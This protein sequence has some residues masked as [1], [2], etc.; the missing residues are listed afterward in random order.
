MKAYK[1]GWVIVLI[2][3][4]ACA[5]QNEKVNDVGPDDPIA[6]YVVTAF[7]DSRGGLWFG[8]IGKGVAHPAGGQLTFLSPADGKGGDVV[9][10]IAEDTNGHCWFAGHEGTGL[11]R[12]D[13]SSF[14]QY[15]ADE[16]SVSTDRAG[17]VW[18]GTDRQV[19]R[20]DGPGFI[21]FPLP[22]DHDT[23]HTYA[24]KPG[25]ASLALQDSKGDLWFRTDG[26]GLIKYDGATFR[27]Y[28]KADGLCSNSVNDVVEDDD[29][30]I[31]VIGMQAYQPAMTHDGGLC[32][33]DGD[34]FITFP[35]IPGLHANDLYTIFKDRSGD[36]WI[37]ATG[38]GVYRF[39]DEHFT[40][41]DRTDR[42]D[43]NASFGLQGMTQ[44]DNGTLW[45][46]FSGGLFR[47]DGDGFVHVGRNGPWE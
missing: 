40:L 27:T 41:F 14:H 10:S 5:A 26:A 18:A 45:C 11:V 8:T 2:L 3:S 28:T 15:W 34:H 9:S 32:R 42:P 31:W 19:F 23:I 35:E 1:Q 36:L 30:R 6:Q 43:L 24:I 12:Y 29:G 20:S 16:T 44:A 37:G 17:T 13:G 38:V 22:I 47:F 33:L 39:R 46:G 7:T 25:R 21:P 4:T